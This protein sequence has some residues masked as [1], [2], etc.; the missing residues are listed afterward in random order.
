MNKGVQQWLRQHRREV[1]FAFLF[2]VAG[3]V[4]RHEI[5]WLWD[6]VLMYVVLPV[7]GLVLVLGYILFM[8]GVADDIPK[9]DPY[10]VVYD[11]LQRPRTNHEP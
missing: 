11:D 5:N 2:F 10:R 8:G 7:V 1:V 4:V 9:M 6:H 3:F